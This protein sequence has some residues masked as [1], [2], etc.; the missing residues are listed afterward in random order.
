MWRML[1]MPTP[2]AVEAKGRRW[3][4]KLDF[5]PL[6]NS[7]FDDQWLWNIITFL[8]MLSVYNSCLWQRTIFGSFFVLYAFFWLCALTFVQ[9]SLSFAVPQSGCVD[10][11]GSGDLLRDLHIHSLH[12]QQ[13]LWKTHQHTGQMCVCMQM[14]NDV[15]KSLE[16]CDEKPHLARLFRISQCSVPVNSV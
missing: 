10:E 16:I 15:M 12:L 8:R 4:Q 7:R 2:S 11:V 6:F 3:R 1:I 13:V 5:F 9:N 14:M